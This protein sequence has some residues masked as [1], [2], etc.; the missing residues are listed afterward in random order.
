MVNV[1]LRGELT[2]TVEEEKDLL[3]YSLIQKMAETMKIS[4]AE[5]EDTPK[6]LGRLSAFLLI[7][8]KRI[9]NYCNLTSVEKLKKCCHLVLHSWQHFPVVLH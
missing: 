4:S 1:N 8:N 5:V 6:H 7:Y 9:H 3:E 2:V